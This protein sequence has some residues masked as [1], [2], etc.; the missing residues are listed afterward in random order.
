MIHYCVTWIFVIMFLV[1]FYLDMAEGLP[2]LWSMIHG[3]I[4][5]DFHADVKVPRPEKNVE[6]E[7]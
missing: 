2:G 6:A 4:P 7:A 5:A 1:H 3:K